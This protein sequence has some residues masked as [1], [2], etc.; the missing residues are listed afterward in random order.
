MRGG[1][2][3]LQHASASA[4]PCRWAVS[5]LLMTIIT[6]V[7]MLS[8]IG[9]ALAWPGRH[10]PIV[11]KQAMK[12]PRNQ[13]HTLPDSVLQHHVRV[14]NGVA[15]L[16]QKS[17]K[18][19]IEAQGKLSS[20]LPS[21]RYRRSAAREKAKD[22]SLDT[23]INASHTLPEP[24]HAEEFEARLERSCSRIET[25]APPTRLVI[26]GMP[27]TG[28]NALTRYLNASLD[29]TVEAQPPGGIWK[30][31]LPFHPQ[32]EEF[33]AGECGK[34]EEQTGV[35]FTVR[36]PGTWMLSQSSTGHEFGHRCF[37]SHT[38]QTC[39]FF[40]CGIPATPPCEGVRPPQAFK[41]PTLLDLWAAYAT[42]LPSLPTV[43]VVRYEDLLHDREAVLR[44]VSA[45]FGVGI[46][47]IKEDAPDPLQNYSR[48]FD[49]KY[50]SSSGLEESQ[51]RL[52]KFARLWNQYG[53]VPFGF[54]E[55]RLAA[56]GAVSEVH[57][58]KCEGGDGIHLYFAGKNLEAL[59]SATTRAILTAPMRQYN[60]EI[61]SPEQAE[62]AARECSEFYDSRLPPRIKAGR[63]SLIKKALQNKERRVGKENI[64]LGQG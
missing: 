3:G 61:P 54:S 63:L 6:M 27:N 50:Q 34:T 43:I 12:R 21:G 45:H 62:K 41:L 64:E 8:Q 22:N 19:E 36:N 53:V 23:V 2:H 52:Y 9:V 5:R 56:N 32:F 14:A 47:E 15:R 29:V 4:L 39:F 31:Q 24:G 60:Y 40:G 17:S 26:A 35:V 48:R 1:G 59:R 18:G 13:A 28:T 16:M 44:R 55:P 7:T 58:T 11:A 33:L 20:S 46:K 10:S 49:T 30:H 57:G 37:N 42:H 51:G 38:G 25:R